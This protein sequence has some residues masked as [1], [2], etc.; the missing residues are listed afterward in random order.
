MPR[1]TCPE[2]PGHP[3]HVIQRG[4]L[5]SACF[6]GD[7][8]CIAYLGWL[9]EYAA[10]CGCSVH[11]YVLMF[12]HVHL[13]LTPSRTGGAAALM[14]SLGGRYARYV[15][16]VHHRNSALWEDRFEAVPVHVRRYLLSCMR[17]IELNPVRAGL[18]ARPGQYRWSSF[19][20]N[21]LGQNDALLR[22]H[23]YYCALGRDAASRQAAYRAL[24]HAQASGART[25]RVR[26]RVPAGN[27]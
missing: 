11:A 25:R 6:F 1:P 9:G 13:L 14:R 12:N 8:D 7:E 27:S 16:D 4:H 24:F 17:Y 20:A 15:Q 22:P 3:L 2:I 10:R 19:G 26:A 23:T 21:A 5:R 18:V